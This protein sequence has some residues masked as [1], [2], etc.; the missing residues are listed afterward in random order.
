[1][2]KVDNCLRRYLA[3]WQVERRAGKNELIYIYILVVFMSTEFI[4][5]KREIMTLLYEPEN[6]W[7]RIGEYNKV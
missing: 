1:M 5:C 6:M 3:N 2:N 7:T 4:A